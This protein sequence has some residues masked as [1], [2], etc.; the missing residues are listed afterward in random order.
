MLCGCSH[1]KHLHEVPW[2]QSVNDSSQVAQE[3]GSVGGE[4]ERREGRHS[5]AAAPDINASVFHLLEKKNPSIRSTPS[6]PHPWMP[7]FDKSSSTLERKRKTT[8]E[9]CFFRSVAVC[10]FQE[11]ERRPWAASVFPLCSLAAGFVQASE[12]NQ[13]SQG[14]VRG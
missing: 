2:G 8:P 14:N 5:A 11:R 12:R 9:C 3:K 13:R 10:C 4:G 6:S 7:R 1:S